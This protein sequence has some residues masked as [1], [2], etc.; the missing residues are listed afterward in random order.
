MKLLTSKRKTK[1]RT[2]CQRKRKRKIMM[3]KER[4]KMMMMMTRVIRKGKRKLEKMTT[5][6]VGL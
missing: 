5:S 6:I 3:R 2:F 4:G 1:V